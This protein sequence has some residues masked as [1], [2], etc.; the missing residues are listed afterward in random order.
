MDFLVGVNGRLATA[1]HGFAK[2]EFAETM[3][4]AVY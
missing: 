2:S 4:I 1:S 3:R